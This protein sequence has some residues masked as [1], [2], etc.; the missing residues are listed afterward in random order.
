MTGRISEIFC[1]M[2]QR[3]AMGEQVVAYRD[4]TQAEVFFH[5]AR[6]KSA[7]VESLRQRFAGRRISKLFVGNNLAPA[8][9]QLPG[10]ETVNLE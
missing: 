8:A 3:L 1:G 2:P 9:F 7:R 6:E 10:V 5:L 4:Y